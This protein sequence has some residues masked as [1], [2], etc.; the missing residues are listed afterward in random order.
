[1][2]SMTNGDLR[3]F[4]DAMSDD[5]TWRWMGVTNWSKTFNGKKEVVGDLFGGVARDLTI[6]FDL[7]FRFDS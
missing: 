7:P 6:V 1:M 3:P 2:E 4:F 5:V